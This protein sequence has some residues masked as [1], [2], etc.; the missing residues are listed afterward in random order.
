[1][2]IGAWKL[3]YSM[4]RMKCMKC[5]LQL[6]TCKYVVKYIYLFSHLSERRFLF[7]VLF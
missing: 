6:R 7:G 4:K 3:N 5:L 1:M 2:L